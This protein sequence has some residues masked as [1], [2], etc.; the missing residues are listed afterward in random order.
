[1]SREPMVAIFK[2]LD[3]PHADMMDNPAEFAK[4]LRE[5]AAKLNV[6]LS[7]KNSIITMEDRFKSNAAKNVEANE[8]AEKFVDELHDAIMSMD[9]EVMACILVRLPHITSEIGKTIRAISMRQERKH[10]KR[11]THLMYNR[12]RKSYDRYV[13]F[14]KMMMPAEIGNPPAIPSRPGNFSSDE[15][16]YLEYEFFIDGEGYLNWYTVANIL[17]VEIKSYMDL[18]DIFRNSNGKWNGR[19]IEVKVVSGE[20]D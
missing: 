11:R 7:Q 3:I 14:M 12:L 8:F 2:D 15:S 1:M 10:S 5:A 17:E 13:S 6:E 9:P 16:T 4:R 20:E 18:V 19:V